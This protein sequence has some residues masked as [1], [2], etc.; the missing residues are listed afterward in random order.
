MVSAASILNL[1]PRTSHLALSTWYWLSLLAF[2]LALLSKTSTVM[3]PVVLLGCAWWQRGRITRRDWLRTSPFFA[4]ALA[5]GLMSIWF[6]A[7]GAIAGAT[8][9]S[10]NFW[11]RLA[12]AGMALWFYL[13]KALLPLNL[14][15]IY[16]RWKIEAAAACRICRCCCGAASWRVCW[17]FRRTWGRHV[18]FGLGCFTVT[19]F[20][21]LGFFDMFFLALVAGVRPLRVSAADRAGGAGGGGA[22]VRG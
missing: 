13:G 19:L 8:V 11:G 3:L 6:Q 20:P 2:V 21:V 15:M 14:S 9:Q 17:V 1:G 10:E 18:L 16:P 22:W 12:G 7:H 4:L 5:F